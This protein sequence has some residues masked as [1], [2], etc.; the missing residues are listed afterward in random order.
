RTTGHQA[1]D[2][3]VVNADGS[4]LTRLTSGRSPVWSPDGSKIAFLDEVGEFPYGYTELFVINADGSNRLR[5]TRN[6]SSYEGVPS[7]S[8]DGTKLV[9][10]VYPV[11]PD[12]DLYTINADGTGDP[13]LITDNPNGFD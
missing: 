6:G 10:S 12:D 9:Y 11:Y 4:G 1:D 8:P 7:W 3:V 2:L 13:T 5:L